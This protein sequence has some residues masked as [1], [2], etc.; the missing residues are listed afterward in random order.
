MIGWMALLFMPQRLLQHVGLPTVVCLLR[1]LPGRLTAATRRGEGAPLLFR[2]R[3][4]PHAAGIVGPQRIR[5]CH[6][7]VAQ[8]AV[9]LVARG[10]G[11][12]VYPGG[13]IVECLD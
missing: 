2:R 6:A 4:D 12:L 11:A 5:E 3:C 9:D 13:E 8:V 10:S 7:R 1:S